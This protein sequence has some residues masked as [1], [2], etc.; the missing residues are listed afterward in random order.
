MTT[1]SSRGIHQL[2]AIIFHSVG[3]RYYCTT[4]SGSV[5]NTFLV[6]F[7]TGMEFLGGIRLTQP[8]MT[9]LENRIYSKSSEY[10]STLLVRLFHL[11]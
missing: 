1:E 2:K 11:C 7:L 3:V 4:W 8:V 6:Q 5:V 9:E 10:P